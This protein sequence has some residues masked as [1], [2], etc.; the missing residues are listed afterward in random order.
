MAVR[1]L[2]P[3]PQ[4]SNDLSA[5]KLASSILVLRHLNIDGAGNCLA[6]VYCEICGF[7]H[8]FISFCHSA[9]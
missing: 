3:L 5:V 2:S 1:L 7:F 4:S 9:D 8:E 6:V